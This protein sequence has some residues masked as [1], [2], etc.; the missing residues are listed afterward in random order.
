MPPATNWKHHLNTPAVQGPASRP[1]TLAVEAVVEEGHVWLRTVKITLENQS[2]DEWVLG[3]A[4][5]H[6]DIQKAVI[7]PTVINGC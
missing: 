7:L 4:H 6:P 2:T 5:H 1:Y 3:P